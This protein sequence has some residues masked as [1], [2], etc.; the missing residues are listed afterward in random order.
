MAPPDRPAMG[1]D[2]PPPAYG[3]AFPTERSTACRRPALL[4]RHSL[5][6]MDWRTLERT[7]QAVWQ[8][9][10]VLATPAAVG[11]HGS[12]ARPVASFPGPAQ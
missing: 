8:P 4:R 5:D 7:P 6:S 9:H 3:Q 10:H 2:S 11:N 1:P 12:A